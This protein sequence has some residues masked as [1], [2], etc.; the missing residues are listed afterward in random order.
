MSPAGGIAAPSRRVLV[1]VGGNSLIRP[2]QRGTIREQ[3]EN[4]RLTAERLAEIVSFGYRMVITHGNGPQV[5][6]QLLRAEAGSSQ[7]Y[8][9]PLDV[10]V[11]ATQGEIG[12]ILQNSLHSEL[13]RRGMN[14]PVATIVTRVKVDKSDPA[15]ENPSKPIGPFYHREDA[16]KKRDEL[17]WNIIEDAARGYRRVV[18]SPTPVAIMEIDVIRR[19]VEQNMVV[20]AVG[21]GGVPVISEDG[22]IKGIEAVID[23]DRSS[24]LLASELRFDLLIISTDVEFVYL[25]YR[26]PDQAAVREMSVKEAKEYLKQGQ[27]Y[28][29]SMGPKIEAAIDFIERGGR[30][31][32]ITDPSNLARAIKGEV[33]THIRIEHGRKTTNETTSHN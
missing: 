1:A 19:C 16:E 7:T 33:G 12:Y 22:D 23:K 17:G 3:F 13:H 29:G 32:I 6:A 25:N 15:F 21:G 14:I 8:S 24:A 10:C 27:F 9:Q 31:V 11:A 28:E 20:I 30:E 5:G 2:G 4:A 26:K 18:P